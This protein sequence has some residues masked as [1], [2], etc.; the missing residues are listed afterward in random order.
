MR[1]LHDILTN[2]ESNCLDGRDM[3]RLYGFIDWN[4][5]QQY[6]VLKEGIKAEYLNEEKWMSEVYEQEFTRENVLKQL[7]RD[8]AFGFDK[9]LDQRGISASLMYEVVK[10]WCWVLDDNEE[11]YNWNTYA[12]YGL[13]LFKAVAVYYGFPN[14]IGDDD[15]DEE[16]YNN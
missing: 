16:K 2:Y 5:L 15:G 12:Y 11:L 6:P 1:A 3:N 8:V 13:P 9:A 7:E 14:E 4:T 10:M